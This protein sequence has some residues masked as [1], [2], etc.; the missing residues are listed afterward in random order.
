MGILHATRSIEFICLRPLNRASI[1]VYKSIHVV[2]P[3]RC[4]T[5]HDEKLRATERTSLIRMVGERAT[6]GSNDAN[7]FFHLI[8]TAFGC[9]K[10]PTARFFLF[11]FDFANVWLA[12]LLSGVV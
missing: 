5:R 12:R 1:K 3:S 10:H 4:H 11:I 7:L 6:T 2:M 9:N 8:P